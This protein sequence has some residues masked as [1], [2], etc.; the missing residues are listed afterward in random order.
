[1]RGSAQ[2]AFGVRGRTQVVTALTAIRPFLREDGTF[3]LLTSSQF[4]MMSIVLKTE[5][6]SLVSKELQKSLAELRA[7][8]ERR[9]SELA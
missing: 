4:S 5:Y 6:L 1:M 3:R 7:D 2:S 9:D 8:V